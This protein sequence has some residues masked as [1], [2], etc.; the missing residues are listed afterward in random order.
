MSLMLMLS[1]RWT[2]MAG[3]LAFPLPRKPLACCSWSESQEELLLSSTPVRSV[4]VVV[5]EV[6]GGGGERWYRDWLKL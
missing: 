5:C 2:G 6:G 4:M 1:F 3:W